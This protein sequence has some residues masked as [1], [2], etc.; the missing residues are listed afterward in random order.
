MLLSMLILGSLFGWTKRPLNRDWKFYYDADFGFAF[1]YPTDYMLSRRSPISDKSTGSI[2]VYRKDR[3]NQVTGANIVVT[4]P[5]SRDVSIYP[6]ASNLEAYE[7]PTY[8]SG[9]YTVIVDSSE[10]TFINGR[11]ALR[12]K[13]RAGELV[14]G[15]L[16]LEGL[17]STLDGLRY[18]FYDGHSAF[19]I[20]TASRG[21][22]ILLDLIARTFE[23]LPTGSLP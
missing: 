20:L 11:V 1:K 17:G 3:K 2:V 7:T 13:Y 23:F 5:P 8:F 4:L 22:A 16:R 12:Q 10:Q 9:I 15:E 14:N 18:V 6:K 19:I 21:N